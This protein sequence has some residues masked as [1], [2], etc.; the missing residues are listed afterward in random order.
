MHAPPTV[1]TPL[2]AAALLAAS[3][4]LLA[5]SLS[6]RAGQ[7]AFPEYL[8]Y[9]TAVPQLESSATARSSFHGS[10]RNDAC[11]SSWAFWE[12]R[13]R[14]DVALW[15]PAN[16]VQM[17]V[18]DGSVARADRLEGTFP[19][20]DFAHAI[21]RSRARSGFGANLAE[22][23]A[24]DA[25]YWTETRIAGTWDPTVSSMN[26]H[27]EAIANATSLWTDVF[28]PSADGQV[29]LVFELRQHTG[30]TGLG[31]NTRGPVPM[32][33]QRFEGDASARFSVEVFNL[34]DIVDYWLFDSSSPIVGPQIV[35]DAE[36]WPEL[37]VLSSSLTVVFDVTAGARYT[38]VS[39]LTAAASNYGS[40]DLYGTAELQ[41]I[42]VTPGLSLL[43]YSGTDYKVGTLVSAVPEPGTWLLMAAGLGVFYAAGRRRRGLPA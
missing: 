29:S 2:R 15:D 5:G 17:T 33:H 19:N 34:D 18:N 30:T 8:P 42:W 43:S 12:C 21:G 4:A 6:A 11:T 27:S 7:V 9:A 32:P 39:S 36:L 25:F 20:V 28:V 13:N 16:Q 40:V 24:R 22:A 1:S 10:Q 41:Q 31:S 23:H 38:L 3:L 14:L 35:A 26:G 37:G